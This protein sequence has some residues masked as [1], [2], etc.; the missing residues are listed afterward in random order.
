MYDICIRTAFGIESAAAGELRHLGYRD[1]QTEN[2]RIL[3]SGSSYD[4]ARCNLQ[5]RT[6]DRVQLKIG[7]FKAGDLDSLFNG[8]QSLPW[9]DILPEDASIT[10]LARLDKGWMTSG[11]TCQ[12]LTKKAILKT[13]EK[14]YKISRFPETGN[15]Y[16]ITTE[17]S[18]ENTSLYLDSSGDGLHKRGY[19]KRTGE[20]PIRETVAASMLLLSRWFG[21][22]KLMDPFCG[23]GTIAIEAA[24]IANGL[25]PGRNRSF[26]YEEWNF[27]DQTET[28]RAREE[29]KEP[30]P[31]RAPGITGSD[32]DPQCVTMAEEAA[33]R[34]GVSRAVSFSQADATK[35]EHLPGPGL[36]LCNPPWGERL[37]EEDEARAL[38][39]AFGKAV[40]RMHGWECGVITSLQGYER[41]FGRRAQKNRKLYNGKL[42]CRFFTFA[43]PAKKQNRN[44]KPF[45]RKK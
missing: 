16:V 15:E 20:A 14:K 28:S 13:L 26:A 33:R 7:E 18:G 44:K 4:L 30:G 45:P 40:D 36:I 22:E 19:R 23:S 24:M 6:A 39:T 27:L 9:A 38:A 11:R 34:A 31:W 29:A 25:A 5:L 35:L 37:G 12:A 3:L 21:R 17:I 43:P 41:A 1:L 8:I 2:G 42:L 10:A 32:I